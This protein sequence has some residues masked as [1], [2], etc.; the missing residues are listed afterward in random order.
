MSVRVRVRVVVVTAIAWLF[1]WLFCTT[2][3]Q[4]PRKDCKATIGQSFWKLWYLH[5]RAY[6]GCVRIPIANIYILRMHHYVIDI[7]NSESKFNYKPVLTTEFSTLS[8][9]PSAATVSWEGEV[10]LLMQPRA[11]VDMCIGQIEWKYDFDYE[12]SMSLQCSQLLQSKSLT[13]QRYLDWS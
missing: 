7:S 10:M 13:D 3:S 6:F 5:R 1:A 12:I 2:L 11:A 4:L 9:S 8:T